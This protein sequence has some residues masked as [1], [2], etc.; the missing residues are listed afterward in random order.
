L[1]PATVRR[2]AR[3]VGRIDDFDARYAQVLQEVRK[4]A[5]IGGKA[6]V[7]S[8]PTFFVNARKVAPAVSPS[9]L[10][11]LIELELQRAKGP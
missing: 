1:S 10:D 9:A 11:A 5:T 6:G 3:D 4:D 8:T 7:E 2:A